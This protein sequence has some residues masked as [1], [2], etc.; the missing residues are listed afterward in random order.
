V[1]RRRGFSGGG[2]DMRIG[3]MGLVEVKG[4]RTGKDI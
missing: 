4:V 1:D 2:L 3:E